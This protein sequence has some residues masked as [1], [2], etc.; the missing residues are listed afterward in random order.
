MESFNFIDDLI[1]GL[2]RV[3]SDIMMEKGSQET[4]SSSNTYA[5]AVYDRYNPDMVLGP[6]EQSYVVKKLIDML[7]YMGIEGLLYLNKRLRR[8]NIPYCIVHQLL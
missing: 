4:L 7:P 3:P 5:I 8:L 1:E 2:K 6:D